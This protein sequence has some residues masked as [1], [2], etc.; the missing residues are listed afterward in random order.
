MDQIWRRAVEEASL[1]LATYRGHGTALDADG[2]GGWLGSRSLFG[3][4]HLCG[5]S[6]KFRD[7]V[8]GLR[9]YLSP[10]GLI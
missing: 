1:R 6:V 3:I 8:E 7:L 4:D 2:I 9:K 5:E 10:V